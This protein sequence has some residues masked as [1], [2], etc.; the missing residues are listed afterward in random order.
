MEFINLLMKYT[1]A[2]I[3]YIDYAMDAIVTLITDSP[4]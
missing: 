2:T 3:S 1:L 4:D